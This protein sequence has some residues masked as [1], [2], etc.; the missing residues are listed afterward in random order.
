MDADAHLRAAEEADRQIS[1]WEEQIRLEQ[2][3]SRIRIDNFKTE[4]DNQQKTKRD[5]LERATQMQ[6][7]EEKRKQQM[8]ALDLIA[9]DRTD[10]AA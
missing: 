4:I 10:Q 6:K 9:R 2:E 7:D 8:I 5:H 1:H 3:Q